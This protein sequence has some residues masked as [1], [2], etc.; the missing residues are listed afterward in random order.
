MNPNFTGRLLDI[1][2]WG[3]FLQQT[4][5]E[6]LDT[7]KAEISNFVVESLLGYVVSLNTFRDAEKI[8]AVSNAIFSFDELNEHAL[9]LRC[10]CLVALGRHALAKNT[11]D[12]FKSKYKDIYGEDFKETYHDL[13]S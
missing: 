11:F 13:V 2:E 6:W 7:L 1:V 5:Y 4:H 10:K 8:I 3:P 9:R 12:K